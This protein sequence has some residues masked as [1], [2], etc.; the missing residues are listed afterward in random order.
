MG[1]A[2]VDAGVAVCSPECIHTVQSHVEAIPLP[3]NHQGKHVLTEIKVKLT[4][5]KT[6]DKRQRR[7]SLT[8]TMS[9][10]EPDDS[11]THLAVP[12]MPPRTMSA[13]G[14][15]KSLQAPMAMQR[16]LSAIGRTK[17]RQSESSP[18]FSAV[19]TNRRSSKGSMASWAESRRSS[20]ASLSGSD[21]FGAPAGELH[22]WDLVRHKFWSGELLGKKLH[23]M[24]FIELAAQAKRVQEELITAC[25][26]GDLRKATKA[27]EHGANVSAPNARGVTPV[28]LAS[29]AVGKS[30]H[31]ALTLLL[32]KGAEIN[33]KAANG[34]S[35]LLH[36]CRSGKLQA[37][38]L[39]LE[40]GAEIS[41]LTVDKQ[42]CLVMAILEGSLELV[43]FFFEKHP[44]ACAALL[45]TPDANGQ[46][47][48]FHAARVGKVDIMKVLL[49]KGAGANDKDSQ[50]RR[51]LMIA[52]E[53]GK[54]KVAKLLS[55]Q[56][57]VN[58]NA[59]DS[60]YYSSLM[61]ACSGGWEELALWL[62]ADKNADPSLVAANGDTAS[63]LGLKMGLKKFLGACKRQARALEG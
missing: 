56:A 60:R 21:W 38:E 48:I 25:M 52:C 54:Q 59:I 49:E 55:S 46:T 14:R 39:L 4:K 1:N 51:P 17:S 22:K 12:S 32:D 2:M 8:R 24:C 16:T 63:S 6:E 58:V 31:E 62:L 7:K 40:R 13:I 61:Y 34:W 10:A 29:T 37:V 15:T 11:P 23:K 47:P 18:D 41:C 5:Q 26:R 33:A 43:Q 50:G 36:A 28:M 27:L 30:A 19:M 35:A 44:S 3:C 53:S 20:K 57:K 45:S 9:T 42:S